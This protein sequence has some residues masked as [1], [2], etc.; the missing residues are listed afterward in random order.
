MKQV[1]QLKLNVTNINSFLKESNKK[2]IGLKKSNNALSDQEIKKS[3]IK[4]KES[5]VEKISPK[6]SPLSSVTAVSYTHLTLPTKA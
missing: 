6:T 5:K 1:Q 2:Y 3:R 4:E